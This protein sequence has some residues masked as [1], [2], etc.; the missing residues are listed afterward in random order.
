MQPPE[1]IADAYRTRTSTITLLWVMPPAQDAAARARQPIT[2]ALASGIDLAIERGRTP[3][4]V[5]PGDPDPLA[6]TQGS[7]VWHWMAFWQLRM[8]TARPAALDVPVTTAKGTETRHYD[9]VLFTLTLEED[10]TLDMSR[11]DAL[12][13]LDLRVTNADDVLVGEDLVPPVI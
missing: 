4:F 9:A 7:D 10:L 6:A 13:G 8:G 5:V 1:Q 3:S 2:N 11:F 12:A